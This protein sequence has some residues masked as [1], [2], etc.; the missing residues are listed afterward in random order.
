MKL[1]PH[2]THKGMFWIEWPDGS[3]SDDFYN[4]TRAS[5][6]MSKIKITEARRAREKGRQS[7]LEAR[8]CV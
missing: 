4:Y 6:H 3:R 8:G 2:E 5:D 7:S 1:V